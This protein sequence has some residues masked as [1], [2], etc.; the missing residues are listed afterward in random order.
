MISHSYNYDRRHYRFQRHHTGQIEPSQP[1]TGWGG[2]L[3]ILAGICLCV[4]VLWLLA[5]AFA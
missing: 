4:A 3:L 5:W 1:L 2:D